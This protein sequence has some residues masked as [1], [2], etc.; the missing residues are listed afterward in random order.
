MA[1]VKEGWGM[2]VKVVTELPEEVEEGRRSDK[3]WRRFRNY[4]DKEIMEVVGINYKPL[5]PGRWRWRWC[6]FTGAI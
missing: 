4:T 1:V 2:A 5:W 6:R 3:P